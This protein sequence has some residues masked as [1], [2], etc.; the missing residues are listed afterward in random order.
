M[1]EGQSQEFQSAL[2]G[3]HAG[4][5]SGNH[6]EVERILSDLEFL[7]LETGGWPAGFFDSLRELLKGPNFLGLTKSWQL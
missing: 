4:V 1:D 3:L 5:Q 2:E 6:D 7:T